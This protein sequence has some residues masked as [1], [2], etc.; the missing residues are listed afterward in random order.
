MGN[1]GEARILVDRGLDTATCSFFGLS[2]TFF[3]NGTAAT[4]A[5]A[6]RV[7]IGFYV[8]LN[9]KGHPYIWVKE[10]VFLGLTRVWR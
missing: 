8:G 3:L 9:P 1:G 5:D 10:R 6:I 4:A 2:L 7:H